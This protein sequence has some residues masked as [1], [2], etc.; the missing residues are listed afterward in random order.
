METVGVRELRQNA[1]KVLARV[2]AG[3]CVGVTDHGRAVAR[4]YPELSS[5]W[6]AMV[7][8]GTVRLPIGSVPL[9]LIEPLTASEESLSAILVEMRN[10]DQR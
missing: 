4:I 10:D 3:E 8:A 5:E 9:H 2:R 1:S 7:E 6:D